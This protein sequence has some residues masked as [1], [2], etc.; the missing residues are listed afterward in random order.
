MSGTVPGTVHTDLLANGCIPDPFYRMNELEVQWVDKERWVYRREFVVSTAMFR[1]ES[2]E[3]VAEGLDTYATVILNGKRAGS[4]A[5][6]F[7]AHRFDVKAFLRKGNNVLE[8]HFDSPVQRTQALEKKHGALRVALEPPRVYA[9]KAQYSFSWD[10]GPKLTTSGIWRNISLHARSGAVMEDPFVKIVSVSARVAIVEVTARIRDFDR[11]MVLDAT[12]QG[13]KTR[14]H[15][16]V[17]VIGEGVK[18]RLTIPSPQLWWPNGYGD[19]PMYALTLALRDG[20]KELQQREVP[21]AVR[22]VSLLQQKDREGKSFI[23]EVNGVKIYCKGA[24]WIPCDNFIPR[25]ADATYE[26]LLLMAKEAHM[27]MIRV[28][29]GGIYEQ[30][31]FYDI[32]DRLGLMVWQDFM[33]ACGEYPELPWF[34]AEA[35]A[36]AEQVVRRLRNHPSIVVWCGNNECEWLFCTE[37][38][39]KSPDEMTGSR[40]FREILPAVCRTYDGTRPYWR[41]SPFGTGF[42]NS[43]TDG[44]HHQ[45]DVWS[46]WKDYKEYENDDARF[47]TEF[48]FQGP[49]NRETFERVT[50]AADR[51]PQSEVM[52]HHN[53]QVEGTER[54]FRFQ[55]A[56]YRLPASFDGFVYQGQLV[57]AEALKFAVE[58]WR[59]R[60]FRTAGSLFWQLNDCWP[61]SSW[62][63]IDSSLRPKAAYFYAKKFFAPIL[64]SFRKT[65]NALEVWGTSD[66]LRPLS[67]RV[68]VEL[69]SFSGKKVWEKKVTARILAN[70]SQRLMKIEPESH[71]GIDFRTHYLHASLTARGEEVSENRFFFVEPKHMELPPAVIST[72]V[73]RVRPGVFRIALSSPTFAKNVRLEL[74]G[75]NGEFSDNYV[76]LEAKKSRIIALKCR[77]RFGKVRKKLRVR[78][79]QDRD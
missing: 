64:V 31:I 7:I 57:Q 11:P 70:S 28:W 72:D 10:W 65:H 62:A 4:T 46:F 13:K 33:Y 63:V 32:C 1:E 5:N 16:K 8:I 47:V 41:S 78:S 19:Q 21:F 37:N 23:I 68:T 36:E 39:T 42:P 12:V 66:L 30:E 29:G 35:R 53:K 22:T 74:E 75:T 55:A 44:N 20:K 69:R 17:D 77:E 48:G 58:H 3:L 6:M 38:P 56:H 2:I 18:F 54:L 43:Q 27:N 9:R 73:R 40:I 50:V 67:A 51:H 24:D 61:V 60:K 71:A 26:K 79:L 14:I 34:L 59:R 76:D 15:T 25:I 45:W 49:A 52:E